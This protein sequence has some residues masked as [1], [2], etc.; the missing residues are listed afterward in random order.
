MQLDP[1]TSGPKLLRATSQS[2]KPKRKKAGGSGWTTLA[3]VLGIFLITF[4]LTNLLLYE[5][6]TQAMTSAR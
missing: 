5:K 3:K 4:F 6:L 2:Y 1:G